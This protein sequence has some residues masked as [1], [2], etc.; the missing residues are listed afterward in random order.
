MKKTSSSSQQVAAAGIGIALIAA[1]AGAFFLYGKHAPKRRQAVRSWMLKAK[2]EVLEQIEQLPTIDKETYYGLIDAA[3]ER[4][5]KL[6]EVNSSEVAGL[7][8]ELRGYWSGLSKQFSSKTP[9]KAAKKSVKKI[10][11]V[12]KKKKLVA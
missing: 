7:V 6:K 9:K 8:K 11:K 4:Y 10:A 5:L 3:A 2:S 1:A 12:A